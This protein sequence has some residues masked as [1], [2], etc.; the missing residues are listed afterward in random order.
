MTSS[1]FYDGT[2]YTVYFSQNFVAS[3]K[4]GFKILRL[5]FIRRHTAP[6]QLPQL[7]SH[8]LPLSSP[9]PLLF[10]SYA[11]YDIHS[12]TVKYLRKQKIP[13]KRGIGSLS[14]FQILLLCFEHLVAYIVA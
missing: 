9:P 13:P 10:I 6:R 1:A 7:I 12:P 8:N 3:H 5:H 11:S 14:L 4:G 2:T